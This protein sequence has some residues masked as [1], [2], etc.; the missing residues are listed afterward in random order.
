MK[1][2]PFLAIGRCWQPLWSYPD[3]AEKETLVHRL[4]VGVLDDLRPLDTLGLDIGIELLGCTAAV[5]HAEVGVALFGVIIGK[6]A[7]RRSVELEDDVVPRSG[8]TRF[9]RRSRAAFPLPLG[10]PARLARV[11]HWSRLALARCRL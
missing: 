1:T 9:R 10:C 3:S 8:R 6:C 4:N 5:G 7:L 2:K 11:A